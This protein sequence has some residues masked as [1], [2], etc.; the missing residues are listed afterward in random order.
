MMSAMNPA[1]KHRPDLR[2]VPSSRPD[3]TTDQPAGPRARASSGWSDEGADLATVDAPAAPAPPP[4]AKPRPNAAPMAVVQPASRRNGLYVR[5]VGVYLASATTT[6]TAVVAG[7]WFA[8]GP[9][10]HLPPPPPET[11]VRVERVEVPV[12]SPAPPAEIVYVQVPAPAVVGPSRPPVG[13]RPP[14][15][16]TPV[17]PPVVDVVPVAPPPVATVVTTP[18]PPVVPVALP[19]PRA[20]TP[21]A[22]TALNGAYAG[23][24]GAWPASFNLSFLPEEAV[25]AVV[26]IDEGG[27][28]STK[29]VTGRYDLASDGT[30]TVVLLVGDVVYSGVVGSG[31]FEGRVTQ[32]GK[33][34]GKLNVQR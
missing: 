11:I 17:A 13:A 1:D 32:G 19:T 12:P 6:L 3:G 29:T 10:V 23:K 27:A 2:V 34:R 26:T 16:S 9:T 8:I 20:T 5:L 31:M 18:P 25:R 4:I 21:A 30:A 22:A 24:A 28:V 14:V 33:S 7:W 15:N